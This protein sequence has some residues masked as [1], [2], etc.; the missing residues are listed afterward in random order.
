MKRHTLLFCLG[1][2]GQGPSWG[3]YSHFACVERNLSWSP[4][5]RRATWEV[6][7]GGS[8]GLI[9]S[10][11]ALS[12]VSVV[13]FLE[14]SSIVVRVQGVT[15]ALFETV[16]RGGRHDG[17]LSEHI[18][19]A[20]PQGFI[21]QNE[22]TLTTMD[23]CSDLCWG[24]FIRE[25]QRQGLHCDCACCDRTLLSIPRVEPLSPA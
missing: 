12:S 9:C 5:H 1:D 8:K 20:T 2:L 14:H 6:R 19:I 15:Y 13:T 3:T 21:R 22:N 11:W 4:W 23:V 24:S 10:L 25:W 7:L 16:P 17:S 18:F